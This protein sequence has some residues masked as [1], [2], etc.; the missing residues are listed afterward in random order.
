M[1]FSLQCS[2]I[3]SSVV[4]TDIGVVVSWQRNGVNLNDTARIQTSHQQHQP[5]IDDYNFLLRFDT[6]SSISDSGNYVCSSILYPTESRDYISN[7]TGTASY[8]ITVIGN[9][10]HVM[11]LLYDYCINVIT[12]A[13]PTLST[14]VAPSVYSG[15]DVAPSN[16][17]TLT[18][19]A[20][21]PSGVSPSIELYWY[22]DEELLDNS[23]S[24]IFIHEQVVMGGM[25]KSSVLTIT[26]AST[27]NSGDYTCVAVIEIPESNRVTSN[28]SAS[29]TIQ[30]NTTDYLDSI[31]DLIYFLFTQDLFLLMFLLF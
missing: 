19:T 17:F 18:C 13:D 1:P 16:T 15:I 31:Y 26:S 12:T 7:S 9:I 25:E 24:E 4:D 5:L 6:L 3:L 22:H 23:R 21:K 29:V 28:Q 11:P 27:I 10:T 20:N 8:T 2:V 14:T 30:G